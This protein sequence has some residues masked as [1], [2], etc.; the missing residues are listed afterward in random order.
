MLT[1]R[2]CSKILCSVWGFVY[3]SSVLIK[4]FWRPLVSVFW[5]RTTSRRL[6]G[7]RHEFDTSS[8]CYP[9]PTSA[10]RNFF[11]GAICSPFWTST[12]FPYNYLRLNWMSSRNAPRTRLSTAPLTIRGRKIRLH[13][14]IRELTNITK[15][16]C[17]KCKEISFLIAFCQDYDGNENILKKVMLHTTLL[18]FSIK[19]SFSVNAKQKPRNIQ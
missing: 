13:K 8:T 2:L 15:C 11:P 1:S 6:W 3:S 16:T 14:K 4:S 17:N 18:L 9:N 19:E 10:T 5:V 12:R 7:L